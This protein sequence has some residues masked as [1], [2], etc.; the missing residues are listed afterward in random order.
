M[1]LSYAQDSDFIN[2]IANFATISPGNVS[3]KANAQIKRALLKGTHGFN[4]A[5]GELITTTEDAT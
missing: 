3:E 4:P 2:S 5:T 1:V